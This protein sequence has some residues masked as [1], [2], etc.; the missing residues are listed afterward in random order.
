M[1]FSMHMLSD[2]IFGFISSTNRS[3]INNT[4]IIINTLPKDIFGQKQT[5]RDLLTVY[6]LNSAS[7]LDLL[8][9]RN[10]FDVNFG[11]TFL[12]NASLI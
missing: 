1:Q 2:S 8:I 11:L 7:F 4:R 9:T 3:T 5:T 10:Y 6:S 12:S